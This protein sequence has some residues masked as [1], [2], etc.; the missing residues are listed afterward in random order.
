LEADVGSW[1]LGR[2]RGALRELSSDG[3]GWWCP[4][5][6]N[7]FNISFSCTIRSI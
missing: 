2:V 6:D 4:Q 5:R 3:E 7:R 1:A